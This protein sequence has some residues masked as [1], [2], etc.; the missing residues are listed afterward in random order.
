MIGK[1]LSVN[2]YIE[3]CKMIFYSLGLIVGYSGS[4]WITPHSPKL[5]TKRFHIHH[6][7]WSSFILVL[8]LIFGWNNNVSVG[9]LTGIALEGLSYKNW[10]IKRVI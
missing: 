1:W 2:R 9:L 6:W 5:L 3:G 7:I 10:K 8:L 4:K